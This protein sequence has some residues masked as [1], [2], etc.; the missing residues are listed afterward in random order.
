MSDLTLL[1]VSDDCSR[2]DFAV[3]LGR[4]Y[5]T[6]AKQLLDGGYLHTFIYKQR[7]MGMAGGVEQDT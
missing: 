7:G 1:Q 5:A 6:V 2:K 4:L 3:Y